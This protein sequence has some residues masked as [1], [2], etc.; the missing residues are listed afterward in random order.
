[1]KRLHPDAR[2]PVR[3]YATWMTVLILAIACVAGV[4]IEAL[5][6]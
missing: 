1:M 3:A 5:T 6:R 2:G 4:L